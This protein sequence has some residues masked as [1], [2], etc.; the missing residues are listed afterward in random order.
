MQ[1]GTVFMMFS[2]NLWEF[3]F[4]NGEQRLKVCNVPTISSY[5]EHKLSTFLSKDDIITFVSF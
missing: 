5:F 2:I 3:T 1:K 4:R